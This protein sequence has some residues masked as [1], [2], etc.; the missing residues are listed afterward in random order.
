MS[1]VINLDVRRVL[2]RGGDFI[3]ET[4]REA[5][6]QIADIL[7]ADITKLDGGQLRKLRDNLIRFQMMVAICSPE[8]RRRIVQKAEELGRE[9]TPDEAVECVEP[10]RAIRFSL[11]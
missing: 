8:G 11:A 10:I 3:A 9:L 4:G 2:R 7:A 1:N 5:Q 6:Q